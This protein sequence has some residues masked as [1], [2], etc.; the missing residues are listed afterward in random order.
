[1]TDPRILYINENR[2]SVTNYL[3]IYGIRIV[4]DYI[5]VCVYS[6]CKMLEMYLNGKL[7]HRKKDDEIFDFYEPLSDGGSLEVRVCSVT[8]PNIAQTVTVNI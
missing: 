8:D 5:N 3:H 4:E 2:S 6:D 7:C 1:M